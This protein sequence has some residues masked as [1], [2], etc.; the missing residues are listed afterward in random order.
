MIH[1]RRN[2]TCKY[3]CFVF[4]IIMIIMFSIAIRIVIID[5]NVVLI[6][7]YFAG[8][9]NFGPRTKI[10]FTFDYQNFYFIGTCLVE[11]ID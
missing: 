1:V 7:L 10:T 9:G 4:N 2:A 8:R 6:P 3:Y 5:L 11:I